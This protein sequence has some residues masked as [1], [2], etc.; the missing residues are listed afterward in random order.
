[1][2][3]ASILKRVN[4]LQGLDSNQRHRG[5]EPRGMTGLPYP[6][7]KKA[8]WTSE[9]R[10]SGARWRRQLTNCAREMRA[11]AS[12]PTPQ[13][14]AMDRCG[15]QAGHWRDRQKCKAR[16][17]FGGLRKF[18]N[19]RIVNTCKQVRL[20]VLQPFNALFMMILSSHLAAG[21]RPYALDHRRI[22]QHHSD[23]VALIV[24]R[25]RN[26]ECYGAGA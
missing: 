14:E 3:E 11:N 2:N 19:L 22:R 24:P 20:I 5:Y 7:K 9:V 21:H 17:S 16:P 10:L 4:W 18:S 25:M 1:M 6:A 26:T 15:A 12:A 23:L 13:A 8:R